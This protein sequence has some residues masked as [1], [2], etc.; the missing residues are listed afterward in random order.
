MADRTI[1][2]GQPKTNPLVHLDHV[3]KT[4]SS[5]VVT[6]GAETVAGALVTAQP[7]IQMLV[8]EVEAQPVRLAIGEDPA[9][10]TGFALDALD[11]VYVY[12]WSN[13]CNTRL[14]REG[15]TDATCQMAYFT[16]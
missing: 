16:E 6:V 11:V 8:I 14:L 3:K 5:S 15:G 9:A 12:G 1:T 2:L 10:D 4:V 13:I 7:R